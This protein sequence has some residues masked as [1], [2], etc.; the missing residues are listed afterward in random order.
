M[1]A[2][3]WVTGQRCAFWKPT[4]LAVSM[5]WGG[6]WSLGVCA[7]DIGGCGVGV[8]QQLDLPISPGSR[9]LAAYTWLRKGKT[10]AMRQSFRDRLLALTP[11]DISHAV[12]LHL[13]AKKDTSVFV[14]FA[15]TDLLEKENKVL[16]QEGKS[17]PIYAHKKSP[18]GPLGLLIS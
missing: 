3:N 4:G 6:H 15:G 7:S 2:K 12:I 8:I 16:S 1:R 14:T 17:L 10:L 18:R 11:H 5:D 9:A 13:L